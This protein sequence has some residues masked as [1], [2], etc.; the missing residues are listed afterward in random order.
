[1]ALQ[2]EVSGGHGRNQAVFLGWTG[3]GVLVVVM[4]VV[5]VFVTVRVFV[6]VVMVV[7]VSV[8]AVIVVPVVTPVFVVVIVV[9][10]C[11]GIFR[12]FHRAR[13]NVVRVMNH[14]LDP[15]PMSVRRFHLIVENQFLGWELNFFLPIFPFFHW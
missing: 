2:T 3:V 8:V 14:W 9:S 13:L 10:S 12:L 4:M 5:V 11:S 6:V 15:V 1:V 7:G